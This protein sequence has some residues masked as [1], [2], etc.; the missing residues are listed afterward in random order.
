MEHSIDGWNIG[1]PPYG[2]A[3]DRVP[4]PVP[5]KAS[6]GRTKTRL[7][8]DPIKA[9]VVEQI[10]TWRVV[11]KLGLPT[12]ANRLN[13]D[14]ARYPVPGSA[15]GW[16]PQAID[17]M[18]RNPKYTGHMV[19]G[20]RRNRR[21]VPADQWLWTPGLVHPV[22]VDRAI[23]DEAQ[24]IGA[25][26]GTSRDGGRRQ[27]PPR[28]RP[29]LRLPGAGVLPG[30]PAADGR[31]RPRHRAGHL[32]PVPPQPR[33]PPPPD[34]RTRS[35]PAPSRPPNPAW[36]R[37]REGS[38]TSASSAPNAPRCSPPSSPPPTPTPSPTG[39]PNSPR[40]KPAWTRSERPRI[41]SC[42]N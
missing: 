10:F 2:Y 41:R 1:T 42:S 19:Y 18:L 16:T 21:T 29:H 27:H 34:R 23:W 25:G 24:K 11:G 37:S 8:L 17:A 36:T 22:I 9:A 12:I 20:R 33:Q 40:S 32:L 39:T 30:L 6:Q 38:F 15:G 28:H 14:P 26:H 13:T 31:P 5:V 3:A 7:A 35:I 4:H